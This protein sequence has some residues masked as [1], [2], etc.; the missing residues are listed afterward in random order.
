MKKT[1]IILLA[2]GALTACVK[3][4]EW[5]DYDGKGI[6]Y[7]SVDGGNEVFELFPGRSKTF[8]LRARAYTDEGG[9]VSDQV[10]SINFKAEPDSAAL[11]NTVHKTDYELC[12]ASCYQFVKNDVMMARFG[13]ASATAKIRLQAI[14]LDPDKV[15][16]LPLSI[17]SIDGTDNWERHT[18]SVSYII[19]KVKYIPPEAGMGTKDDPYYL[20]TPED[21]KNM[22][23]M[24]DDDGKVYFRLMNDIDMSSIKA[25][26]PLNFAQPY[27]RQV[28]FDGGGHTISNFYCD[29]P[30]YASFFGVLNG[31]CYDVNFTN[32]FIDVETGSACAI[33]G[34][35]C[36]TGG[37]IT[38]EAR[39]VHV[40]GKV[41]CTGGVNGIGGLFGRLHGK[42]VNCSANCEVQGKNKY[43]GGLFGYDSGK[44][45]VWDCWTAGSVKGAQSVGGI[46]GGLIKVQTNL[47]NC[48][49][50]SKV[51]GNFGVGGIVGHANL[52]KGSATLPNTTEAENVVE[53]CLAWNGWVKA[54]ADD[55]GEH[56]SSG[57]IIGYGCTKN[58][59]INCYRRSDLVFQ[60]CP[61]N[62]ANTL[63]NQEN[64]NPGAP[65]GK[66]A[67]TYNFAYHGKAAE[68]GATLTTVARS[69]GWSEQVWDF[70][71]DIP[72]HN[73]DASQTPDN[74]GGGDEPGGGDD[75]ENPLTGDGT[76]ANPWVVHA[77]AQLKT[78]ATLLG[79]ATNYIKLGADLDMNS[80]AWTA[81]DATSKP[82]DLDG[83]GHTLSNLKAILFSVLNGK[84]ANLTISN[85]IVSG[86]DAISGILACTVATGATVENVTLSGGSI[87]GNNYNGGLIGQCNVPVTF[88]NVKV[89]GTY[90][91]GK[92]AG[93]IIGFADALVNVTG[94]SYESG[95]VTSTERYCGGLVGSVAKHASKFT[96]C[97]V[98]NATITGESD[99]V[100]GFAGQIRE[101]VT[102]TRCCA[103]NVTVKGKF[104]VGGF[105]GVFSGT[106]EDC[107]S[108]GTASATTTEAK[109]T[110]AVGGLVGYFEIG[111]LTKCSSSTNVG[112][113][114]N[115]GAGGLVG[116]MLT[117]TITRCSASG[118]VTESY[119]GAGG[120]IGMLSHRTGTQTISDCYASGNVKGS[121][122][123]GGLIGFYKNSKTTTIERCYASGEVEA[124]SG[125]TGG[126][127]GMCNNKG[128][129][130]KDC[131]AW[132]SV[133]RGSTD[134]SK[135]SSAYV[136]GVV[137]PSIT[138]TNN[139]RNPE[140][141]LYAVWAPAETYQHDDVSPSAP[142]IRQ[143]GTACTN[144][145]IANGQPGYP[146]YPYHGKCVTGK[147][148]SALAS[149]T[150]GWSSD[151]WDFSD[152]LPKLK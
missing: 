119:R 21:L 56:Y 16:V 11:Y 139:Y 103:E 65:L 132:N 99:R 33:L 130:V 140:M 85:A 91:K 40:Q 61:G 4:N 53:N 5:G 9:G 93:G 42:V 111:Q 82:V 41:I 124:T 38:G 7:A 121:G 145:G 10:L 136:V 27:T 92:L 51:S 120:L 18:S 149:E 144:T 138:L 98:K 115:F 129:I 107:Y 116:K 122:Y 73:V 12:P 146:L 102:T 114:V 34:A 106:A 94:C 100:G 47:H 131:A 39:N 44:S 79:S 151:I 55:D 37:D 24:M 23:D 64:A 19:F 112:G 3:E 31:V 101:S 141:I 127:I 60:E 123:T 70:S 28:D 133:V 105:A 126:L 134:A 143:D 32:A 2:L 80:S 113:K 59:L 128:I 57:A 148:L 74:P 1:I 68:A 45:D 142:L 83:D 8:D 62:A 50:T 26:L 15:Y 22:Y 72:V 20:R 69:L 109:D 88:N 150:L 71:S 75:P 43:V 35:Y 152:E 29:S 89:N 6:F 76:Q 25:W 97:S 36:G 137:Y 14:G 17:N 86:G 135:W 108:S 48:Y 67:G 110:L 30:N 81:I 90:V 95:T 117:G 46:A 104:N 63:A 77:P 13:T 52:D 49:S 125:A 54:T 87:S 84:V 118:N 147:T 78:V 66:R 58:Y 96:D